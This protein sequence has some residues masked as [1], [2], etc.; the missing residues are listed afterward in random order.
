MMECPIYNEEMKHDYFQDSDYGEFVCLNCA[1][2]ENVEP[3]NVF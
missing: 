3:P 2:I 1:I